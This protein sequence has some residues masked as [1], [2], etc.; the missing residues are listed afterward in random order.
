[1]TA[2]GESRLEYE[3]LTPRQRQVLDLIAKGYTNPQIADTLGVSID[4]AKWHVREIL[5]KLGVDSRE[6][7]AT[8]RWSAYGEGAGVTSGSCSRDILLR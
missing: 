2:P 8:D 1:M 3:H 5:S 7:L 6:E 4:G